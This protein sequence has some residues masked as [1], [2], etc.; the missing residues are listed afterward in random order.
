MSSLSLRV[1]HIELLTPRIRRLLL[2]S[3]DARPLPGFT[4]GAHLELH[5]PGSRVQRRAYSLVNLPDEYHY[6]IAVQLEETSTGGSRWVHALR[7]GDE[8][9]AEAPR[10]HFPLH[11]DTEHALL[12]AGGIGIT[13]MLGMAR[14]LQAA[15]KP[16]TLHYAGRDAAHMAY[17]PEARTCLDS[18][19]WI[20]GG[21]PQKR[22]PAATILKAPKPGLHLYICGPTAMLNSVLACARELGWAED[23]LHYELFSGALE[24]A[25]D[26]GFEVHLRESGVTLQ[27]AAGQS[28]LD[29]MLEAGLDPM[30][31]CR[32]GDCGVCVTQVID[33]QADHRDICL[34]ERERASG[35]F[36]TCVS[37]ARSA[38]L[39]LDL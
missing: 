10:N 28:V 4:A 30:F 31:D 21:D 32:R 38:L 1:E 27:V 33:G 20:S 18:H 16:F 3:S 19:C 17:L 37:R 2:V 35:S 6:E 9:Q 23:H 39:V 22:F 29:A 25:G 15:G 5:V 13:P 8:L 24:M 11:E 36:C 12:I 26:Q 14:S 34:S 7:V